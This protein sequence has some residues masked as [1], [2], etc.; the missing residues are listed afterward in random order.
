ME[1]SE[2]EIEKELPERW[3]ISQDNSVM[4]AK[5]GWSLIIVIDLLSG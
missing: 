3:E 4:A 2:K 5:E 1:D